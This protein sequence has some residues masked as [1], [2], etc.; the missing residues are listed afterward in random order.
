MV[1]GCCGRPE[2]CD[3]GGGPPKTAAGRRDRRAGFEYGRRPA[4]RR[5]GGLTEHS[6]HGRSALTLGI[7]I[8]HLA[9]ERFEIL[10]A[11]IDAGEADVG[12]LVERPPVSY[13]HLR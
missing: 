8:V 1:S 5:C 12:D 10:E 9:L 11:L 13:T 2:S 3:R 6:L 4:R 7:E